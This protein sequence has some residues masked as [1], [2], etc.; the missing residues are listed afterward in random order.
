MPYCQVHSNIANLIIGVLANENTPEKRTNLP[1][2]DNFFSI[3]KK[4]LKRTGFQACPLFESFTIIAIYLAF[5]S[6]S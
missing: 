3:Q 1:T 5:Y 6:Y 4:P 2:K